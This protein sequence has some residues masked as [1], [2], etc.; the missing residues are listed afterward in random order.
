MQIT[1]PVAGTGSAQNLTAL[2]GCATDEDADVLFTKC[3]ISIQDSHFAANSVPDGRWV[4]I[5][6]EWDGG[7]SGTPLFS[8]LY[9]DMDLTGTFTPGVVDDAY[10]IYAQISPDT[11]SGDGTNLDIVG[12]LGNFCQHVSDAT[13][14]RMWANDTRVTM[15]NASGTLTEAVCYSGI[16]TNTAGT[17]T[18]AYGMEVNSL[19]P[20]ASHASVGHVRFVPVNNDTPATSLAA[21]TGAEDGTIV[22][23]NHTTAAKSG[24]FF[25]IDGTWRRFSLADGSAPVD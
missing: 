14:A 1:G 13:I 7:D 10:G 22:Y 25:L 23:I 8:A 24:F 15:N 11:T 21:L 17:I 19:E 20:S 9:V 5:G 3:P 6:R 16:I 18:R 12:G 2:I 4:T